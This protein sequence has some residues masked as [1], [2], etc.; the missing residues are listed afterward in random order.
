[1]SS[2]RAQVKEQFQLCAE[3]LGPNATILG[4]ENLPVKLDN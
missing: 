4:N 3:F 1:M 2:L